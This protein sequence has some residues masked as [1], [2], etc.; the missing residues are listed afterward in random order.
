M[1]TNY[2]CITPTTTPLLVTPITPALTGDTV[3]GND[4]NNGAILLVIAGATPTNVS[5]VDPG[6]TPAGTAAA[7]STTYTVA[8]NTTRAFGHLQMAG[9]I[10]PVANTVGLIYSSIATIT[11]ELVA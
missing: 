4:I 10:D 2:T 8:A 3:N 7:T 9:Y 5:F 6:H 1:A 11:A